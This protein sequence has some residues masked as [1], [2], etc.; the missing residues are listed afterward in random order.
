MIERLCKGKALTI[1]RKGLI[2]LAPQ[3]GLEPRT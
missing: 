3:H 2:L 1:I